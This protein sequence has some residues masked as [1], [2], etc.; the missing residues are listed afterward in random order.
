[1]LK[2]RDVIV[3]E[4]AWDQ[5]RLFLCMNTFDAK[6]YVQH[7]LRWYHFFKFCAKVLWALVL[8]IPFRGLTGTFLLTQIN[9]NT[10]EMVYLKMDLQS[11][12]IPL[13]V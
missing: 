6:M 3:F 5:T 4:L 2:C 13:H 1:M 12:L 7:Q 8:A 9:N 10:V 11:V